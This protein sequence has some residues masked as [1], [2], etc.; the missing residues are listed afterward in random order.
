MLNL[1]QPRYVMPIHGDHKRLYL[2][3]KLAEAV[4][5]QPEDDLQGTQRAA[6]RDRRVGRALRRAGADRRRVRGRGGGGRHRGRR[7]ARPPRAVGGRDLH[8]G[9]DRVRSG[10][11]PARAARG[12]SARRAVPAED[13][14]VM[15][16]IRETVEDVARAGGRRRGARDLAA[17]GAP[18]RGRGGVH[19]RAPAPPADGAAGG[20]RG[21]AGAIPF[22]RSISSTRIAATCGSNW[23]RRGASSPGMAF[24]LQ[25]I[26]R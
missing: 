6:A 20:R 12:H 26:H 19:L 22:P 1:T 15:D 13:D 8:R 2:H 17:P 16:E 21:L 14:G 5:I 25:W 10:R 7:A 9:G 23:V 24:V 11:P 4:G 3:G 18:A